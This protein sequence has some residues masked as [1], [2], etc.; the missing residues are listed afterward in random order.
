MPLSISRPA[1]V[2]VL[3]FAA[4]LLLLFLRGEAHAAGGFGFDPRWIYGLG[5]VVVGALL[6]AWRREYGELARQNLP[7]AREA[8]LAVAVGLLVFG[9]WIRLDAPWMLIGSAA[10]PFV[11]TDADGALDWALIAVRWVGAA[12]LVPVMEE[13]FWRSFLMRWI[14]Q[15][16]FLALDPTRVGARALLL[17]TFVFVLV[18]TQWLAAAIAG[19]AYAWL[20]I[21]R[22]RLWSAVIAH[23]VT[24]GALGLWVVA[25]RHWQFW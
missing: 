24:N 15:P 17:S 20:Y 6:L 11:P 12:L 18:H 21:R 16:A 19:F 7:D 22:G 10:A 2:R 23:A 8:L 14:Q 5:V 9:L 3:P 4:F 1:L 25:G 13:L